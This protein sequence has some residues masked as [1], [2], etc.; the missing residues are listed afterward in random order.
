[1][2][3]NRRGK[4]AEGTSAGRQWV[5]FDGQFRGGREVHMAQMR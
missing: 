4:R 3:G 2:K 5:Q 1:M